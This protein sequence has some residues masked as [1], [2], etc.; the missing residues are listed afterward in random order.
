MGYDKNYETSTDLEE[1][2]FLALAEHDA[3]DIGRK[4]EL[5]EREDVG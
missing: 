3:A 1:R 4:R 2:A 5:A